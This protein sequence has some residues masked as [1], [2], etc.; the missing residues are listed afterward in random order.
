M[1]CRR[2]VL[3][4]LALS[5]SAA[6]SDVSGPFE[7]QSPLPSAPPRLPA[8]NI[9]SAP[10]RPDHPIPLRNPDELPTTNEVIRFVVLGDGGTGAQGQY[11]VANAVKS[12][13]A[14][15]G[16]DFALYLGDNIYEVG[17][18]SALDHQFQTKF[19]EPYAELDFPFYV[20]LGNHD[21]G[22][23]VPTGSPLERAISDYEIAYTAHSEK[24]NM[25]S[26]FYTFEQ[27]AA[28]FF[29]LDTNGFVHDFH[30]LGREQQ[31]WLDQALADTQAPW[32][33]AFGHHPYL[34]NGAHGSAGN[35]DGTGYVPEAAHG[36]PLAA[37]VEHSLCGKTQIYFAGHNH[38]REW[39]EP[40]CGTTFIVS[41]AAA[42]LSPLLYRGLT[43]TRFEDDTQR[44]FLW[45][46]L[47]SEQF[48]GVF[49]DADGSEAYRD[50]ILRAE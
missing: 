1:A 2:V 16:C 37:L 30:G 6:C 15:R 36:G 26:H 19:E 49:Y 39:L 17:V 5:I 10:P 21:Y 20:V 46:E 44:G 42:K 23:P 11:E 13:C 12:V 27:G 41:G 40:H 32:K 25:P 45:A 4:L 8:V 18:T 50:V 3:P 43:P 34:S 14:A 31:L 22:T 7:S 28:A 29:G 48:L 38:G 33:M 24:W 35:F 9:A 47:D